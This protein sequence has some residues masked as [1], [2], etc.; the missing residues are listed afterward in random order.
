MEAVACAVE[1]LGEVQ[2]DT[3]PSWSWSP[4]ALGRPEMAGEQRQ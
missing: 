1:N 3:R 4:V 2:Y